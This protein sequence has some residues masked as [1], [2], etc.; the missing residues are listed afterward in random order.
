MRLKSAD[1]L[2]DDGSLGS[3]VTP[4]NNDREESGSV[5]C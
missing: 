1:F 3:R 5:E 2:F 4:L